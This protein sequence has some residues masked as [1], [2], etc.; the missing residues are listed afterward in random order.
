MLLFFSESGI[1][2]DVSSSYIDHPSESFHKDMSPSHQ[3]QSHNSPQQYRMASQEIP[4]LAYSST[5]VSLT[6]Y[7]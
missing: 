6:N 4:P 1:G 5:D 7:I 2:T 3:Y